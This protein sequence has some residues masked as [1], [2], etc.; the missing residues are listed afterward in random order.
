MTLKLD[1]RRNSA[2]GSS[3]GSSALGCCDNDLVLE[4]DAV[5]TDRFG[6]VTSSGFKIVLTWS[7]PLKSIGVGLRWI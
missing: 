2:S 1:L 7:V 3:F 5:T 6:L 4:G